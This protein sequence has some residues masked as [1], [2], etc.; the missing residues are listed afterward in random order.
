MV[1]LEQ[2]SVFMQS[3]LDPSPMKAPILESAE[4]IPKLGQFFGLFASF[5]SE[6]MLQDRLQAE[7]AE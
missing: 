6:P 5:N 1:P 3:Q 7:L 4:A 2:A